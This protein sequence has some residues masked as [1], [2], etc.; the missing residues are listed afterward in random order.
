MGRCF[1][2]SATSSLYRIVIILPDMDFSLG[3]CTSHKAWAV[4]DLHN[5]ATS[6]NRKGFASEADCNPTTDSSEASYSH[7]LDCSLSCID[8]F[9][10]TLSGT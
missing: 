4:K 9:C 5:T 8:L 10:M 1:R 6:S 3:Y 7:N 2:N